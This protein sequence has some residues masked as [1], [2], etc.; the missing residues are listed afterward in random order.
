MLTTLPLIT[1]DIQ[2]YSLPSILLSVQFNTYC[3]YYM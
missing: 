1:L 3:L 2:Y